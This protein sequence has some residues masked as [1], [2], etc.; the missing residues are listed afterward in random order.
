MRSDGS[1]EEEVVTPE[2]LFRADSLDT[3]GLAPVTLGHPS[4]GLVTP[5]NWKEFSVGASGSQ[6]VA[7]KDQGLIDLVFV[8]GDADAIEAVESGKARQVSAGYLTKVQRGD[9]GKLYQTDRQYNHFAIV[10]H[11][12]AGDSVSL[13]IDSADDYAIQ[14]D[15]GDAKPSTLAQTVPLSALTM[16]TTEELKLLRVDDDKIYSLKAD[17][18]SAIAARFKADAMTIEDLSKQIVDLQTQIDKLKAEDESEGE[19]PMSAIQK[20]MTELG[21][22]SIEEMVADLEKQTGKADQLE[23][24]IK[25]LKDAPV[26]KVDATSPEIQALVNSRINLLRSAEPFLPKDFKADGASDRAIMEA[27]LKASSK[28]LKLDGLSD[29]RVQGRFDTLIELKGDRTVEARQSSHEATRV[30]NDADDT[31]NEDAIE[32]NYDDLRK[33]LSTLYLGA[34]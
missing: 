16:T 14:L 1:I 9:D 30:A 3:A 2:E 15:S 26:A 7:R 17:A 6:V 34:K 29:E 33:E 22:S 27:V 24:E 23:E 5:K 4:V 25:K 31:Y 32:S 19:E 20:K 10:P 18:H 11:G 8:V 12:R 28:D 21:Y 13:H